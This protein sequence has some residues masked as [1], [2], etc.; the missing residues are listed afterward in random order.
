MYSRNS[1]SVNYGYR[2]PAEKS[3]RHETLFSINEAI[4]F[5]RKGRAFKYSW[6]INEVKAVLFKIRPA[7]WFVPGESHTTTVYTRC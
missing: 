5:E 6:G 1:F 3:E 7:L 2:D 4:V